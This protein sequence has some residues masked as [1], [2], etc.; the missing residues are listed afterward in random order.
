[1]AA[2]ILADV[3]GGKKLADAAGRP[4][5]DSACRRSAAP[6]AAAGVPAQLVDPLFALKKGEP[7]MVETP[8]GFVVA[9]LANIGEADPNADPVGFGQVRDGLTKALGDD[10]QSTLTLALRNRSNPKVNAG[11]LDSVAQAE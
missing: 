1:M 7:T 2:R 8:D 4:A 11:A 9:V 3:K 10:V 5:G 6:P